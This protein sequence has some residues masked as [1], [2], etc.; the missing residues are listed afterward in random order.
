MKNNFCYTKN[1]LKELS[2]GN[3]KKCCTLEVKNVKIYSFSMRWSF[4]C[5][6][7][8]L[9]TPEGWTIKFFTAVISVKV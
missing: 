5:L 1:Q 2:L 6:V 4:S 9:F 8:K 3:L 7:V